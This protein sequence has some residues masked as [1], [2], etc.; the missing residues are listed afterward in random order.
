MWTHWHPSGK[1]SCNSPGLAA[2][3]INMGGSSLCCRA[4]LIID[5]GQ[6]NISNPWSKSRTSSSCQDPQALT[7]ST[8]V[9][10]CD[11]GDLKRNLPHVSSRVHAISIWWWEKSDRSICNNNDDERTQRQYFSPIRER[12]YRST[13]CNNFKNISVK[14]KS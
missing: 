14:N 6:Y 7:K 5:T 4:R 13:V 11:S 10:R 12:K 9:L 2:Q 1:N 8:L 3:H